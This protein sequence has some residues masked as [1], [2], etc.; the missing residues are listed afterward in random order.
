MRELLMDSETLATTAVK[1]KIAQTKYLVQN[2]PEANTVVS[3]DGSILAYSDESKKKEF[4][5]CEVP[6]QVKGRT[7]TSLKNDTIEFRMERSDLV[8]YRNRGGTLLF[9]VYITPAGDEKIYFATLT[10]YSLN[11][12]LSSQKGDPK[13]KVTLVTLPDGA[14]NLCHIVFTFINEM[15]RQRTI[16]DDHNWTIEEVA[17]KFGPENIEMKF[18]LSG[19]DCERSN[20]FS[21][22]KS[23]DFYIHAGLKGTDITFPVQ[24]VERIE[25]MWQDL[26]ATIEVNGHAY[27]EL[28]SLKVHRE[29]KKVLSIGKGFDFIDDQGKSTVKYHLSGNLNER[30]SQLHILLDLLD[31]GAVKIDGKDII[32]IRPTEAEMKQV[33]RDYLVSQLRWFELIRE[34]MDKLHVRKPLEIADISAKE[35]D[36]LSMLVNAIIFAKSATFKEETIPPVATIDLSNLK[37]ILSFRQLEDGAYMTEDFF[38]A[39][40]RCFIDE[41]GLCLTSRYGILKCDDFLKCDNLFLDDVVEDM[42]AYDNQ[43]HMER[44]PLCILEMIKAYDRDTSRTDLMDAAMDLICW[45]KS[46]EPESPIHELNRLQCVY[47]TSWLSQKEKRYLSALVMDE[48]VD[49]RIKAGAYILLGDKTMAEAYITKLPEKDRLEF[50][51]YPIYTLIKDKK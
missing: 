42:K 13:P 17:E 44:I 39:D 38:A 4:L 12:I 40:M 26:N 1:K 11:V 47:R 50:L 5:V 29:G 32:T 36:N 25:T 18:T 16:R 49:V 23:G 15:K 9:V 19:V 37:L 27:D 24:H 7:R 45:L 2:I 41:E 22:I 43:E 35:Q 14:E 51:D 10:P 6:V 48:E 28:V 30:I 31:G 3:W 34:T 46:I 20:P 8:N 33:D 21:F